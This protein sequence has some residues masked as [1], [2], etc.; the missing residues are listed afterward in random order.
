[1]LY[2]R[3]WSDNFYYNTVPSYNVDS[4]TPYLSMEYLS[5]VKPGRV[6]LCDTQEYHT[7]LDGWIFRTK[8]E[9]TYR[10]LIDSIELP[11]LVKVY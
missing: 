3:I 5:P 1:M 7:F 9:E 2:L 8:Y 6:I 10:K 11:I 4:K